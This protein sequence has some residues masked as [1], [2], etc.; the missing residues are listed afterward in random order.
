[1]TGHFSINGGLIFRAGRGG[2][3]RFSEFIHIP[4]AYNAT[5][6]DGAKAIS[7]WDIHP[8]FSGLAD[9]AMG[10][11]KG[12]NNDPDHWGSGVDRS[13]PSNGNN[14]RARYHAL[15]GDQDN[16]VGEKQNSRFDFLRTHLV[17]VGKGFRLKKKQF[18]FLCS[19]S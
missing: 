9:Q 14:I 11:T 7:V 17:L 16:R 19:K 12:L 18:I 3:S 13:R 10:V 6:I 1:L 4:P 15:A 8:E 5:I 2:Q